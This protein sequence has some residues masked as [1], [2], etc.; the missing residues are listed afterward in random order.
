MI[1]M[2]KFMKKFIASVSL[3]VLICFSSIGLQ[4]VGST[5]PSETTITAPA[6]ETA[7]ATTN[8]TVPAAEE[9]APA[10]EGILTY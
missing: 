8:A 2:K 6:E 7:N 10:E 3:A 4:E 5:P 1:K 9:A